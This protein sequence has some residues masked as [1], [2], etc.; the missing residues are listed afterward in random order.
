MLNFLL[1]V[2]FPPLCLTCRK[3]L[4][5]SESMP[6]CLKCFN[7]IDV[8][9]GFSC[10]ACHRRLPQPRPVCHP[11]EKFVLAAAGS[12]I[13]PALRETIHG[14]KYEGMKSALMP[15]KNLLAAYLKKINGSI[16]ETIKEGLIIPMP[17]HPKKERQRGFN[18]TRELAVF[19]ENFMMTAAG[20]LK[21]KMVDNVLIKIKNTAPQAE[22][23]NFDQRKINV[24]DSFGV[25]NAKSIAGQN[26]LLVDDV[27]TSGA[28]AREAVNVLKK[29]GAKKIVVLVLAKA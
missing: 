28:T 4:T 2:I 23:K 20:G 9:S 3:H 24:K 11:Q 7:S 21:F 14:F 17:L 13:N 1:D 26:V 15:L 16:L 10:P 5:D 19:A 29:A 27:F 25:Q 22:I 6:L 12:Y 18:Q 8:N